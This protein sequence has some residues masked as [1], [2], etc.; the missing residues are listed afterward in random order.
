MGE[1]RLPTNRLAAIP[2]GAVPFGKINVIEYDVTWAA[3][4]KD[5]LLEEW[6]SATGA[7]G[8]K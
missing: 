4:H 3:V 8:G 5:D 1:F 6:M 7:A 2:V